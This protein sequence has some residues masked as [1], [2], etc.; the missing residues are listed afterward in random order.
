MCDRID[1][2]TPAVLRR[3]ANRVFGPDSGNKATIVCM[4]GQ[5]VGDYKAVLRKY[6]VAGG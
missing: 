1:E 3:V 2:V 4:G 6:S 5:E